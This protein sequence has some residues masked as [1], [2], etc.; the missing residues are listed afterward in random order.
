MAA[1]FFA[2]FPGLTARCDETRVSGDYVL[3]AWTLEG[4]RAVA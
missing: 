2:E 3:F 4:T 1:G